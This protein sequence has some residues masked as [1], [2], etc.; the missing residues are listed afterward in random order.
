MFGYGFLAVV[1]VLYLAA[2]GLDP[3]AIGIVLTLTLIGD[4]II[5]LWLTTNAD[6]FGRRR[7]LVVGSALMIVAGIVFAFTS[8]VPL[9]IL[10]GAIGVISPTGNEVGPFLAIEQAALT[11]DHPG[12]PPD[13]DLR[14]VQPRRL[15]RDRDG[16]ARR[17]PAQPGA[18]RRRLRRRSTPTGRSSSATR[19]IGLVMVVGFWRLGTGDRGAAARG[20]HA[21]A[22]GAGSGSGAPRGSSSSCRSC[23]RS[24]PSVAASSRR[25]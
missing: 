18:P 12:Q 16:R 17:R 8:W 1:L 4:T 23:S 21:T 25:A 11:P 19:C 13:G 10:A 22:S 5:S 3:L 2:V 24:T 7:V 6:R 14:L 9:L 20:Q 15:R